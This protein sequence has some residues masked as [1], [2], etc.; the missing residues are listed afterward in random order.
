MAEI[1]IE[2]DRERLLVV[3]G[4]GVGQ[5]VELSLAEELPRS[6]NSGDT[7]DIVQHLRQLFPG[8]VRSGDCRRR[9][10]FPGSR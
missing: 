10:C 8:V 4:R 9:S 3:R 7:L 6:E 2:W 1:V 5:R